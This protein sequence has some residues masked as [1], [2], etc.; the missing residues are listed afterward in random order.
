MQTLLVASSGG[1]LEE[2]WALRP[3]LGTISSEV[4]WV[5]PHTAQSR[6]LLAL[7]QFRSIPK[8]RPRDLRAT[9]STSRQAVE[10]LREQ[11][12]A[13]VVSTGS[14]PAVPFLAIGR[15]LG[16]PCHFIE[17]A[18][19]VTG[20]SLTARILEL[21]PGVHCYSQNQSWAHRRRIKGSWLYR[22]SVFDG[23]LGASRPE[24]KIASVVVTLGFIPYGFRRL[25]DALRAAVPGDV[26][27]FWQT[28]ATDVSDL[29]L[30]GHSQVSQSELFDRMQQADLVVCHAGVGSALMAMRAGHCPL[31]VPRRVQRGEHVDDH[32]VEIA[33]ELDRTGLAVACEADELSTE[34]LRE[35]ASRC[36]RTNG[37]APPFV[38]A[39]QS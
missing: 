17:S 13:A 31:L 7:E 36:V 5:T 32:Q 18:A 12:W 23:F 29:G 28:G 24:A 33:A 2:L 16:L 10:I 11:E 19:R 26:A 21:I 27:V 9:W 3:R 35:V 15:S 8:A 38:L 30:C 20:P 34:V 1:H 4:V 39:A 25:I 37:N 22:G 6:S 14:L